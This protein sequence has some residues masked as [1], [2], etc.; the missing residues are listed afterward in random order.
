MVAHRAKR[1]IPRATNEPLERGRAPPI[2]VRARPV[3][4]GRQ[5]AVPVLAP[6]HGRDDRPAPPAAQPPATA[7][8]AFAVRA[9]APSSA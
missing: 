1:E 2:R 5:P 6:E 8:S 3:V 4:G 7:H 9:Q